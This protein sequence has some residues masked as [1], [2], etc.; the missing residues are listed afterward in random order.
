LSFNSTGLDTLGG[1]QQQPFNGLY[2]AGYPE[3]FSGPPPNLDLAVK[4]PFQRAATT[5]GGVTMAALSNMNF[6]VLDDQPVE[7]QPAGDAGLTDLFPFDLSLLPS[8]PAFAQGFQRNLFNGDSGDYNWGTPT[9]GLGDGP[10]VQGSSNGG[11]VGVNGDRR[12]DGFHYN[13][14]PYYGS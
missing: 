11:Y 9:I 8:Q 1:Y 10:F 2:P 13:D 5:Y 6:S 3:P 14:G 12:A 4:V 7:A